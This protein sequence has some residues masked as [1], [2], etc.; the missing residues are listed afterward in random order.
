MSF[1]W[2]LVLRRSMRS[3]VAMLPKSR[4]TMVLRQRA[5]SILRLLKGLTVSKIT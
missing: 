2:R 1:E 4:K 3:F 5:L